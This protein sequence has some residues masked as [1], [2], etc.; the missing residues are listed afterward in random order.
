MKYIAHAI[1]EVC[2]ILLCIITNPIVALFA[3][4]YGQLPKIFKLWQTFD[5]PLDIDW[6]VYE[7]GCTLKIFHYDFNKHYKYHMEVHNDDDT[8]IPGYVELLDPDFTFVEKVQRYFCRLTW[9]YRNCNYGF[10]YFLNGANY[11]TNDI[12][13]VK[14]INIKNKEIWISYVRGQNIWNTTWCLYYCVKYCPWFRLRIYLGWKMKGDSI[15]T[16]RN[17]KSM[18]AFCVWPF[19]PVE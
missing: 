7:D 1:L 14:N 5:N 9:L 8:L 18:I 4:E 19:K 2:Y 3:D 11:N 6:M 16:N 12:V 17:I 13:L 15:G 10:S